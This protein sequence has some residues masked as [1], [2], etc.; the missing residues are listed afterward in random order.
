MNTINLELNEQ[1]QEFLLSLVEVQYE[2]MVDML[3][4]EYDMQMY[5]CHSYDQDCLEG[6]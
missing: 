3:T 6:F 1:F 4:R 2:E 5:A